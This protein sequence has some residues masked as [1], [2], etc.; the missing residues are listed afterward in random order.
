MTLL[1]FGLVNVTGSP[2]ITAPEPRD[3]T[4][5]VIDQR[6]H[7]NSSLRANPTK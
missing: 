2:A 3:D 5:I 7:Y 1:Q 6:L 4:R